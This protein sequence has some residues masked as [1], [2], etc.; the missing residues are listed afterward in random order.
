[1]NDFALAG[2]VFTSPA[3][4]F[5]ELRERPRFLV[6]LL[7]IVIATVLQMVWYYNAVDIEWLKDHLFSGNAR[8]DSL[9]PDARERFMSAM[10]KNTLMWPSVIAITVMVPAIFALLS[11]YYLLA[12]KVTN[13]QHT[14]K[15]WFSL[16]VWSSLP[17]LVGL[18]A[19]SVILLM[20]GS[21]AQ[22]GPSELQ[23]LSLNEL[24][25]KLTPAHPG[26]QLLSQINP[27][28]AWSWCL[29]II[30]VKTWSNR[31][32]LFSSVFV[33]LPVVLIYGGWALAVF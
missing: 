7:V 11:A 2:Q 26:A 31:S 22:V 29:S 15:H 25:F 19:G 17:M 24:F 20:N 28:T 6:P 18:A 21:Q 8:M 1:M 16:N 9:P 13:V 3:A 27:I 30:A 23:V 32:W 4:A 33:L 5:A 10:T 12:G 14:F